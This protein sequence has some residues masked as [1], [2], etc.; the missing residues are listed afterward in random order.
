M[1]ECFACT[2]SALK[3]HILHSSAERARTSAV[4]SRCARRFGT[5]RRSR[6]LFRVSESLEAGRHFSSGC[7]VTLGL[8]FMH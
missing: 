7:R 8:E 3:S 4:G 6:R 5:C 2:V 1:D